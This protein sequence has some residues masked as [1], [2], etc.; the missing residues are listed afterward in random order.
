M[1]SSICMLFGLCMRKKLSF[2][3]NDILL[4]FTISCLKSTCQVL[5]G[6][7]TTDPNRSYVVGGFVFIGIRWS[8]KPDLK[9]RCLGKPYLIFSILRDLECTLPWKCP[10]IVPS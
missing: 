1:E 5:E 6:D 4:D 10:Q 8:R 2:L 7:M 9:Q 3:A